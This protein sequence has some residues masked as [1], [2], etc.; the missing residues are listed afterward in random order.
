M[1][2]ETSEISNMYTDIVRAICTVVRQVAPR[3]SQLLSPSR[4]GIMTQM[5]WRN[6]EDASR[7][8]RSRHLPLAYDDD[9]V[10]IE[11]MRGKRRRYNDRYREISV[12]ASSSGITDDLNDIEIDNELTAPNDT[13]PIPTTNPVPNL[14]HSSDQDQAMGEPVLGNSSVSQTKRDLRKRGSSV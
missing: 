7:G 12:A 4:A 11:G 10:G 13:P 8:R 5:L 2:P 3:G 1:I 14:I 6:A 9:S